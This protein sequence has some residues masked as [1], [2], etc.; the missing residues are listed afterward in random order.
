VKDHVLP[1]EPNPLD[2]RQKLISVADVQRLQARSTGD[3]QPWPRTVGAADLG[4][5]SDEV[6]DWLESAWRAC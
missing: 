1:A 5:Q 6:E 3:T 2:R 4:V